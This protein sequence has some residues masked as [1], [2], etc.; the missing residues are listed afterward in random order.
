MANNGAFSE[1]EPAFDSVA[2]I[3]ESKLVGVS[4]LLLETSLLTGLQ[5]AFLFDKED[6]PSR[7]VSMSAPTFCSR[8]SPV[9]FSLS[10]APLA[11]ENYHKKA[12]PRLE[13]YLMARSCIQPALNF[14]SYLPKGQRG[15]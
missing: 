15:E 10:L 11:G 8:I 4:V 7:P 13:R 6:P 5:A 14:R 2:E 1:D 3:K 9:P 12:F